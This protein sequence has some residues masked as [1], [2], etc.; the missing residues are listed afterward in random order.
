M[1]VSQIILQILGILPAIAT[2]IMNQNVDLHT[3]PHLLP[4]E[5]KQGAGNTMYTAW[6][7]QPFA[8]R[9][10]SSAPPNKC[11]FWL[12]FQSSNKQ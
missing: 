9:W 2:D 5:L 7:L 3:S 11:L 6:M 8:S 4:A 10:L 12:L 1:K